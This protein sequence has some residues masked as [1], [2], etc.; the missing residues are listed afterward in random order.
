MVQ[1]RKKEKF[2]RQLCLNR[3][4]M[5]LLRRAAVPTVDRCPRGFTRTHTKLLIQRHQRNAGVE[6]Q[7]QLKH[8][9]LFLPQCVNMSTKSFSPSTSLLQRPLQLL[10]GTCCGC[11]SP[12]GDSAGP[13]SFLCYLYLDACLQLILQDSRAV[14]SGTN[15][16]RCKTKLMQFLKTLI[17]P[18]L[19]HLS[20]RRSIKFRHSY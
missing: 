10:T 9:L 8:L 6:K 2:F 13:N 20:N 14:R 17:I 11:C 16:I 19:F 12:V 18:L 1:W 5:Q 4:R 7:W 15:Q 3:G